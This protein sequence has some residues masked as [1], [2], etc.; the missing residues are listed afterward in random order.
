M[1]LHFL[2]YFF[3]Y[4][5]NIRALSNGPQ[6]L[7]G[8]EKSIGWRQSSRRENNI[9]HVNGRRPRP[10]SSVFYF[11]KYGNLLRQRRRQW[12]SSSESSVGYT[13]F[14]GGHFPQISSLPSDNSVRW[15][16]LI[17]LFI[18]IGCRLVREITVSGIVLAG[19]QPGD[20]LVATIVKTSL[21]EIRKAS[22]SKDRGCQEKAQKG[23]NNGVL[24]T[25]FIVFVRAGA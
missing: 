15:Q 19:R 3:N 8:V 10:S 20:V 17:N 21:V 14:C 1:V 4:R 12:R 16:C 13:F 7:V 25:E 6:Y 23:R 2:F 11:R 5:I 9:R 24:V 22:P 18:L